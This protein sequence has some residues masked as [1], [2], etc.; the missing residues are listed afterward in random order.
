MKMSKE[1]DHFGSAGSSMVPLSHVPP[2]A[3]H[4]VPAQE[5]ADECKW[6]EQQASLVWKDKLLLCHVWNAPLVSSRITQPPR[7]ARA[8][9][10]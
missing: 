4:E 1:F 5:V 2:H 10:A 7:N 8:S 9:H 6:V 3:V